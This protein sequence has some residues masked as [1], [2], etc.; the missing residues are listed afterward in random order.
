M[1]VPVGGG[2]PTT[3]AVGSGNLFG[4]TWDRSSYYRLTS[5][6][7]VM[8]MPLDGG[9]PTTLAVGQY[10]PRDI[11][12]SSTSLYWDDYPTSATVNGAIMKLTP[13]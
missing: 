2:A 10:L 3:L 4:L 9:A 8:T 6:G 12:V 13:K 11:L 1:S 7:R 5:D